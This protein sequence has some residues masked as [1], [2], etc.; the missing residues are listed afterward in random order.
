MSIVAKRSSISATAELLL[1]FEAPSYVFGRGEARHFIFVMQIDIDEY[2][3]ASDNNVVSKC[4]VK[5][6]VHA[7]VLTRSSAL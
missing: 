6:V 7:G 5:C 2:K 3:C 4:S 1:N